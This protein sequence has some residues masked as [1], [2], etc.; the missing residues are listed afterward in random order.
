MCMQGYQKLRDKINT[1]DVALFIGEGPTAAFLKAAM[2]IGSAKPITWTHV[3][4]FWYMKDD[5]ALCI[6]ESTMLPS[7]T[8]VDTGMPRKG[9]QLVSASDRIAQYP[10]QVFVRRIHNADMAPYMPTLRK[11]RRELNGRPYE[12]D[13][14]EIIKAAYDGPYGKNTENLKSLFCSE[15]V[16]EMWQA[17][18]LLGPKPSNEYIPEDFAQGLNKIMRRGHVGPI[19]KLK[20]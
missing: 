14:A 20:G 13:M 9:V 17:A 15:F 7:V 2:A 11:L 3:G 16:A 12:Q 10:G 5:D 18:A 1:M 4:I 8:N 6:A 19:E